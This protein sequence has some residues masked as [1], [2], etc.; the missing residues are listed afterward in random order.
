MNPWHDIWLQLREFVG[1]ELIMLGLR[2]LPPSP[3]SVRLLEAFIE[4]EQASVSEM[5]KEGR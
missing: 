5:E 3:K 4:F 1:E 2:A